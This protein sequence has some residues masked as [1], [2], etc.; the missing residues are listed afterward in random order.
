VD[1]Q[2]GA[3]LEYRTFGNNVLDTATHTIECSFGWAKGNGNA[4]KRIVSA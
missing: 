1:P 4:L 3:A 2:S